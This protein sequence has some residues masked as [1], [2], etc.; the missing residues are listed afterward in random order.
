MKLSKTYSSSGSSRRVAIAII[1]VSFFLT[2]C[3]DRP[4]ENQIAPGANKKAPPEVRSKFD[5]AYSGVLP[6][7]DCEGVETD[8]LMSS[9]ENSFMYKEEYKGSSAPTFIKTG[10][11]NTERGYKNDKDA[12]LYILGED[13]P[14]LT[15]LYF[16]RLS[17][18]DSLLF[19]LGTDRNNFREDLVL[20]KKSG[21]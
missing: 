7:K 11:F 1:A 14:G 13:L 6:C 12:T 10:P 16:V 19:S 20:R 15:Q 5:Q 3:G 8:L 17:G 2:D 9:R 21:S 4:N 18:R